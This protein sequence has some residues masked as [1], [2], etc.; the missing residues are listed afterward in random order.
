MLAHSLASYRGRRDVTLLAMARGGVAVAEGVARAIGAPLEVMIARKLGVPGIEEVAFGAIAEGLPGIVADPVR[1]FVGIPRRVAAQVA[2]VERAELDR[3]V[4]RYRGGRPLP[5]LLGRTVIVIDDGLATGATLRAAALALRR[6]GPARLIAAVPVASAAGLADLGPVFD[7]I[8]SAATPDPFETVSAWYHD[9]APVEDDEVVR[10]LGREWAATDRATS[11]RVAEVPVTIP[12]VEGSAMAGDLG[13]P[14][15]G[16]SPQG[17]VIFAH[18]GGSSRRSY[19]NRYLAARL[20]MAGW[21]TLRI[22][23]LLESEQ[24]E[25]GEGAVRF[26]IARI[27]R[28]LRAATEWAVRERIAGSERLV[29]FGASTGAAAAAGVAAALPALVAGIVCRA[30]RIDLA[31]ADPAQVITPSLLVVGGADSETL[32]L[33]RDMAARLSGPVELRIVPGA[34]HTFEES[35]ALGAVGE[36]VVGWLARLN[37]RGMVRR[38]FGRLTGAN[39]LATQATLGRYSVDR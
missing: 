36:L 14:P 28:R 39:P 12:T 4:E 23:L 6:S 13:A 22:D 21:A 20:R 38:W 16:G 1:R 24:R 26:D 7:E 18:G 3:R 31:E 27:T 19:R 2:R 37:R 9:F 10:L 15:Q 8:V 30:G 5:P 32:R 34:G 17:L 33:N 11:A 35:G 29:L 25:D